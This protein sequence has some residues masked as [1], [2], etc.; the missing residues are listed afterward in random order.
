MKR[1]TLSFQEK[2]ILLGIPVLFLLGTGM[3][4]LF[5]LS[6]N[7]PLIGLL[8]PVNESVWEHEKLMVWPVFLWWVVY[9]FLMKDHLDFGRWLKSGLLALLAAVA[10]MPLL[11]YFY[12]EAFGTELLWADILILLISL[13]IGQLLGLHSYRHGKS[14]PAGCTLTA[15]L[16]LV[17]LFMFFTFFPP[18]LPIFQDGTTGG[19]GIQSNTTATLPQ[20]PF[21]IS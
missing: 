15:I 21:A 17:F 2:W 9:G 11:Y 4:F 5:R 3:H 12:T 7:H 8:A 16:L 10:A 1:R 18:A 19:Y 14:I 13:A 6:G 20:F